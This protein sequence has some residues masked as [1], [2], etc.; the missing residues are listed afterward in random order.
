[1]KQKYF[2][3]FQ[4]RESGA[5]GTFGSISKVYMAESIEDAKEQCFQDR[6][7]E[8]NFFVLIYSEDGKE[9]YSSSISREEE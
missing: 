6:T 5:I 9:R 8:T 2:V 3:L 7:Y 4:G 1:M